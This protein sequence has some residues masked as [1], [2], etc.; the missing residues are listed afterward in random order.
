MNKWLF[1][2]DPE[3]YSYADLERDGKAVWDGISN[4]LALQNLRKIRRGDLVFVYHSGG[5]TL[6]GGAGRGGE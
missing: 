6:G 2:S 4:N 5:R 1:K 3:H